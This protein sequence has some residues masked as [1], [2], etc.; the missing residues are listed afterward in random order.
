M[1]TL[2]K[3]PCFTQISRQ[4]FCACCCNTSTSLIGYEYTEVFRC[5]R[6]IRQHLNQTLGRQWIGRGGPVTL[7]A[8]RSELNFLGLWLWGY[9]N[10]L[11]YAKPI[12]DVEVLQQQ[13][14]NVCREI[15][16]KQG[17]FERVPTSYEKQ[18]WKLS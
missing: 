18:S 2:S 10:I 17:I 7:P 15:R 8:Q 13:A 4:A 12:N 11:M 9:L 5:P 6:I 14:E 3:I 1:G 16:V